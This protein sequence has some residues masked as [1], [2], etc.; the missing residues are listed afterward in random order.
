MINK[1]DI[2]GFYLDEKKQR[3]QLP[4]IKKPTLKGIINNYL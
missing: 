3:I 2:G 1:I 4:I